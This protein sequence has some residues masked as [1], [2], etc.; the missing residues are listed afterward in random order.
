MAMMISK[1]H[2]IIQSKIVWIVF[3]I[4]ISVAFVWSYSGAKSSKQRNQTEKKQEI[5][6]KLFGKKVTR[7]EFGQAY[8]NVYLMAILRTGQPISINEQIDQLLTQN[9]WQRLA[10]LKKAHQMD[11][12]VTDEQIAGAIRQQPLFINQQTGMFDRNAYDRFFSQIVPQLGL[13]MS[14]TDFETMLSENL[15]IDKASRVAV[16]GALVTDAEVDHAF[17]VYA[18]KIIVKY[19]TLPRSLAKAPEVTEDDAKAYYNNYPNQFIYPDK[20]KVRYVEFPVAEFKDPSEVTEQYVTNYYNSYKERFIVE[21]TEESA[22]PQYQSLAEAH[23]TIV[24]EV[25]TAL[26]RR[27]AAAAAG[28]FVSKLSAPNVTFDKIAEEAEKTISS[29]PPFAV[30]DT[31]RGIDP[32]ARFAQTA[33]T[34]QQDEMH[35]YSDPVV[36]KDNIYVMALAGKMPSFLPEYDVVAKDAMAAAKLTATEKAYVEKAEAVHADIESVLKAG[37]SFESAAE[38]YNLEIDSLGPFS[39]EEPPMD[40]L[41]QNILRATALF[42]AGTLVDLIPTEN[43]YVLAYVTS[44]VAADRATADPSLIAQLKASV[45]NDKASRL[46]AAWQQSVMEEANLE[47]TPVD[48]GDNS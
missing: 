14:P 3:A 6:G 30:T 45:A 32:T 40:D 21:G 42:N 31:V 4:L 22:Q 8:R 2:K 5:V 34:L 18:D 47:L 7:Q 28:M 25:A 48:G 12:T 26:A 37:T 15:L 41:G 17:H 13:R 33:F 20:V 46:A 16:Q 1:F 11:L 29:T 36:G 44:K 35:Y 10:I 39:V 38:K 9:A 43:E 23:D 19:A 24:D 27:K